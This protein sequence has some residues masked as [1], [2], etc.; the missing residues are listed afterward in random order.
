[1]ARSRCRGHRVRSLRTAAL[2]KRGPGCVI[3]ALTPTRALAL[4]GARANLPRRR[5][6]KLMSW[7]TRI[8]SPLGTVESGAT[9][10]QVK[11]SGIRSSASDLLSLATPRRSTQPWSTSAWTAARTCSIV[12]AS[13]ALAWF[14]QKVN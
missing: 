1:M 12:P 3:S 10:P 7:I 9:I 2:N 8:E 6:G 4:I 13:R 5:L 11:T 14:G